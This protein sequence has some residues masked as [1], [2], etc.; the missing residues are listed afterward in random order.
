MVALKSSSTF[1]TF[2]EPADRIRTPSTPNRDRKITTLEVDYL[3]FPTM[4]GDKQLSCNHFATSAL[5]MKLY[6]ERKTVRALQAARELM[7]GEPD[8]ERL[9]ARIWQTS[10]AQSEVVRG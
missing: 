2:F 8:Y 10:L 9:F 3:N 5:R 4:Q 1:A 7:R 6:R